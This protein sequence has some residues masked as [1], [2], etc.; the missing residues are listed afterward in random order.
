VVQLVLPCA[1]FETHNLQT[2]GRQLALALRLWAVDCLFVWDCCAWLLQAG[3]VACQP[4]M[5]V[6]VCARTG[7]ACQST[8]HAGVCVRVHGHGLSVSF[9][10]QGMP[11]GGQG[12]AEGGLVVLVCA[13]VVL[14]LRR[15]VWRLTGVLAPG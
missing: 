14:S 1:L 9:G 3:V 5:P 10:L 15:V 13:Q 12:P 4:R 11:F 6:S 2:G 7:R 8:S